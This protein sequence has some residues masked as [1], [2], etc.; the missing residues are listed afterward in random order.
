[1]NP[2]MNPKN[3]LLEQRPYDEV[4]RVDGPSTQPIFPSPA[5]RG[6]NL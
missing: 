2:A 1:M 3:G 6:R 5:V 4:P